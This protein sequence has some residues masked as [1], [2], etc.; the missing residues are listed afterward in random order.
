MQSKILKYAALLKD[1]KISAVE[2]TA[3][4][5]KKI[6]EAN[7]RYNAFVSVD[8][9]RAMCFARLADKKIADGTARWAKTIWTNLP[10][11]PLPKRG[12]TERHTTP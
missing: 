8:E 11:V 5:L 12:S 10:W 9:E 3:E 6:A 7:A 4:Y 1:K 2:L